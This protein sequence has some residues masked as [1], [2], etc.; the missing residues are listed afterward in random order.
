MCHGQSKHRL[1]EV[2][3]VAD[4]GMIGHLMASLRNSWLARRHRN[5]LRAHSNYRIDSA[6]VSMFILGRAL[7][8]SGLR[9]RAA[10][11]F[12]QAYSSDP[13][14]TDVLEDQGA[15]LDM[16]GEREGAAAK[17]DAARRYGRTMTRLSAA[18]PSFR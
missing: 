3:R 9:P 7:A 2:K 14:L 18:V 1:Y 8:R 5:Y 13:T 6:A 12:G 11:L 15:L 16:M 17:Y 4:V 10:E